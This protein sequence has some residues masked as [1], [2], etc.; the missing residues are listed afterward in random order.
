MI[1]P[2]FEERYESHSPAGYPVTNEE[3]ETIRRMLKGKR[4]ARA[5]A[6]GGGGEV[7]VFTLLPL[8]S[9]LYCIDHS[10]RAIV[11]LYTK[12]IMLQKLGIS[13][14]RKLLSNQYENKFIAAAA[15]LVEDL[16]EP[17]RKK[18]YWNYKSN[19]YSRVYTIGAN[20]YSSMRREWNL[21][22]DAMLKRALK[23]LDRVR[24]VHGDLKQDLGAY[25]KFDLLYTS[26]AHEH[27]DRNSKSIKLADLVEL[28]NENGL[29][30][31][32]TGAGGGKVDHP[33]LKRIASEKGYRTTW[34]YQLH[35]KVKPR[36]PRKKVVEV[37]SV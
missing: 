10:H 17:L 22:T 6:I 20:D 19:D 5:G 36:K 14:M 12:L 16:P 31:V 9:E 18:A 15:E 1:L 28:L 3:P 24:I 34:H 11:A 30:L 26:N 33:E 29:L 13:K 37:P 25:G 4:F 8:C 21:F 2:A 32:S 7:S 23:K 27:V 35:Q